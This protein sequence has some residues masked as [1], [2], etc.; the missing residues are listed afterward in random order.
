MCRLSDMCSS[1]IICGDVEGGHLMCNWDSCNI[2]PPWELIYYCELKWGKRK[3][4]TWSISLQKWVPY[5]GA[6]CRHKWF[7]FEEV[8]PCGLLCT[9]DRKTDWHAI[10]GG[11]GI[12]RFL[13]WHF[14]VFKKLRDYVSFLAY[15]GLS[16]Y[17]CSVLK[18]TLTDLTAKQSALVSTQW[19][20]KTGKGKVPLTTQT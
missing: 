4:K 10:G 8:L 14:Q 12:V 18:R 17:S 20:K 6:E 15:C 9:C 16:G 2:R 1:Y 19:H 11:V 13:A 3:V 5:L 7:S